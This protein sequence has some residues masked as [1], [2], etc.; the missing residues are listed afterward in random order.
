[1][2][3]R[4]TLATICILKYASMDNMHMPHTTTTRSLVRVVLEY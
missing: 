4:S 1:M 2:N 3:A